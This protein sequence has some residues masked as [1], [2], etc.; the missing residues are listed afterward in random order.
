M[1]PGGNGSAVVASSSWMHDPVSPHELLE[2]RRFVRALAL[3]LVGGDAHRAD[4][5]T[6][7]TM[8]IAIERPPV[9]DGALRSWLATVLRN[10]V[11]DGF[12]RTTRRRAREERVARPEGT[13]AADALVARAE[14]HRRVV[15]LVL[16]L[17]P[18][19]REVVLLR[20]FDGLTPTEIAE[21]TGIACPT[22]RT[23]LHRAIVR[24]RER[25]ERERGTD[26][27][28][29]LVALI[30][31][32]ASIRP[33][34]H[35]GTAAGTLM[36]HAPKFLVTTL[37]GL[38]A[39]G[40]GWWVYSSPSSAD[41]VEEAPEVAAAP[42]PTRERLRHERVAGAA[43]AESRT[44]EVVVA[45]EE[46]PVVDVAEPPPLPVIEARFS[47]YLEPRKPP[48]G[49]PEV[50]SIRDLPEIKTDGAVGVGF[51]GMGPVGWTRWPQ[52]PDDDG[53]TLTGVVRDV[54]GRPVEGATVLR[55]DGER[56]AEPAGV[57]SFQF[58]EE[59]ATT[60][61]SGRFEATGQPARR[62]HLTANFNRALNRPRGLLIDGALTIEPAADETLDGLDLALPIPV[63][64]LARVRGSLLD[65]EGR[66]VR[67]GRLFVGYQEVRP[68]RDGAFDVS[69]LNPGEVTI[70]WQGAGYERLVETIEL[71]RSET[72]SID[73]VAQLADV[74][75]LSVGGRVVDDAGNP[76]ADVG[77]YLGGPRYTQSRHARTD[78]DGRFLFTDLDDALARSEQGVSV[79]VM[80]H[81][82][83]GPALAPRSVRGVQVP[84]EDL[85]I[86]VQRQA[87][88]HVEL[89]DGRTKEPLRIYMVGFEKRI[90]RDGEVIWS[91]QGSHS[92]YEDDGRTTLRLSPGSWRARLRAKG[93]RGAEYVFD[94]DTDEGAE[95]RMTLE[96]HPE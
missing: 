86:V 72:R 39:L 83:E 80:L 34:P 18:S 37:V 29:G 58:I 28:L 2:H 48:P 68:D 7:Q 40:G 32:G 78:A 14:E 13:P 71:A 9:T 66:P 59:I 89:L 73:L 88:V 35:V 12:R 79:S 49:V 10:L 27:R 43:V 61:A 16:E 77:M 69:G 26:W 24:L 23:R 41:P 25:Y 65:A 1:T 38:L 45:Q 36:S 60:D 96:L 52:P 94:L 93:Y 95:H 87:V 6:Q 84:T 75:S 20:Y 47:Q 51:G 50:E 67:T 91:A 46:E 17:P 21:R 90:E 74:G 3:R 85:E 81:P 64:E 19:W 63:G 30:D 70:R 22:V 8:L 56:V 11:R 76:V 55:V 4:D 44:E 82:E 42:A 5:L 33:A 92:A 15:D 62:L 54:D 57:L 31:P 53:V